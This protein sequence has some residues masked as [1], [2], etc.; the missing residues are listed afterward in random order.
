MDRERIYARLPI[1]LQ[2]LA[3]HL[4]GRRIQRSRYGPQFRELLAEYEARD[5]LDTAA[6]ERFRDERLAAFVRHAFG[7][8]P[9]YRERRERWGVDPDSIRTLADL[10]KLPVLERAE[11]QAHSESLWSEACSRDEVTISHTSG[12]TGTGLRFPVTHRAHSEQWALWWRFRRRHG[13]ELDTPCLYFGGRSIVPLRQRRAPFWRFNRPGRQIL[14]SGYHLSRDNA[15][16]YLDEIERHP[17]A[18]L[19]GY[20]SMLALLAS[21]AGEL[22]RRPRIGKISIGSESLLDWQVEAI[23]E[24]FGVRPIQHYGMS[25][26]VA[27]ISEHP[28]GLLRVDEDYAAVEFVPVD[29]TTW[30]IVG[31]NLSNPAFPLLRYDTGDICRLPDSPVD[32]AGR[33]V[34]AR[35]DGRRED[36]VIAKSGAHLGRLDHIFKDLTRVREA[37]IH[38]SRPGAMTLHVVRAEGY[39]ES[40]DRRLREETAKRV[41]DD[42]DFDVCYVDAVERTR[43]GKVRFV[44][45]TVDAGKIDR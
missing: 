23:A 28:D 30:R 36:Y 8:V 22:G 25:E 15:P 32:A 4:E 11:V 26:G 17:G 6:L 19:H 3:V 27:N 10:Q 12:S 40:D 31:T 39:D 5:A 1:A 2:N 18:W 33:R 45:S 21:F 20:P 14:F 41:G 24:A 29:A 38:Q 13:I 43:R 44:V 35:V 7:S 42:V 16:A 34:V 37:Q 9:Y